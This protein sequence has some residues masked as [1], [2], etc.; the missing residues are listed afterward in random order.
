VT[1]GS[2]DTG[3][4]M[5]RALERA[6]EVESLVVRVATHNFVLMNLYPYTSGHLMIAPRRHV[7]RLTGRRRRSSRR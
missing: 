6:P 7:A 2:A 4:V 5:C 1:A 3:C